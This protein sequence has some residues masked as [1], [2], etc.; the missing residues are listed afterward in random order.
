[1]PAW[2]GSFDA[3]SCS[4]RMEAESAQRRHRRDLP[5]RR[6][7]PQSHGSHRLALL[8]TRALPLHETV[9]CAGRL[10]ICTSNP[11]TSEAIEPILA[12]FSFQKHDDRRFTTEQEDPR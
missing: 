5:R 1:M 6:E 12:V 4:L 10:R 2:K 9:R 8:T 7:L 3:S 11:R